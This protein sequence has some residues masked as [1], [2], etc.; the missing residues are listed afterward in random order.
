M[1][2]SYQFL[3]FLVFK[4]DLRIWITLIGYSSFKI[5]RKNIFFCEKVLFLNNLVLFDYF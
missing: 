5:I 2:V 3:T 1:R 4:F